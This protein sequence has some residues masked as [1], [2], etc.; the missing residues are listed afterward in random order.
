[1]SEQN[2]VIQLKKLAAKIIGGDT[3][4]DSVVGETITDVLKFTAAALS[5]NE[6]EKMTQTTIAELLE[7]IAENFSS[8][9]DTPTLGILTV[10]S[11]E[12]E[13]T[14]AT[15]ITVSPTIGENHHY[16][17]SITD[18][19][20]ELPAYGENISTTWTYMSNTNDPITLNIANG[21]YIRV[22]EINDSGNVVAGGGCVVVS[23]VS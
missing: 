17:H 16:Y 21:K 7:I 3:S 12:G 5:N 14:G 6:A 13:W 9:G 10:K 8:G 11:Q 1:M 15:K 20:T 4:P 23:N 19:K 2:N 22:C 18:A